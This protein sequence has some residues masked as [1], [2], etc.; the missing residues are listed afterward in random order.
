MQY[1]TESN[2]YFNQTQFGVSTVLAVESRSGGRS[3][4]NTNHIEQDIV[5][6]PNKD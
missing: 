3:V 5:L 1:L 6:L 4:F 2:V